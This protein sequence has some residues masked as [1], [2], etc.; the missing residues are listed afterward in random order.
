VEEILKIEYVKS[1]E[2]DW[3][4]NEKNMYVS[5]L[6][7]GDSPYQSSEYST[8][9]LCSSKSQRRVWATVEQE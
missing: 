4:E 8:S 6:G 1:R 2:H 3:F 9:R 5:V 7:K